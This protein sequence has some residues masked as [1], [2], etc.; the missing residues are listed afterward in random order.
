MPRFF[1][2]L[3]YNGAPF[4]GWQVQPGRPTVQ[5]AVEDALYTVLRRPVAV[6]GA[7]RTDTGVNARM[8]MAHLDLTVAE[9]AD[10]S[11]LLRKLNAV[12]GGDVVC[13]NL[14][15][16]ADDAHA[17]FDANAR[18]YRYYVHHTRSPFMGE[19]SLRCN[20]LD[21]EAMNR[22]A[23]TLTAVDDFTSFAKLHSDVSTNIC[24]VSVARWV[25]IGQSRHYFEISANRFLRNMVRAVV[26]TLLEVGRG[27]MSLDGFRDVI[28]RRNRCAAGTSVPGEPLYLWDIAYPYIDTA[29]LTEPPLS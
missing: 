18:T 11:D 15:Q 4:H 16:V 17:R 6:T 21:Y 8:M 7:G 9:A 27:K 10:P 14:I 24:R 22:A 26:G 19:R 3:C 5:Q 20:A 29:T 1:L 25:E 12:L 13:L 28:E 2:H 23:A